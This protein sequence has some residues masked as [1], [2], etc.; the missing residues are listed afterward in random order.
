MVSKGILDWRHEMFL[1]SVF[2]INSDVVEKRSPSD[3]YGQSKTSSNTLGFTLNVVSS[4]AGFGGVAV[5]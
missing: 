2:K 4:L 1:F 5:E 3:G